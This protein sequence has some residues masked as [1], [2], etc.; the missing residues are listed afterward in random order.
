MANDRFISIS[1]TAGTTLLEFDFPLQFPDELTLV[2]IRA[3]VRVTLAETVDYNITVMSQTLG[4]ALL[5]T[6][7]SLDG[8]VFEI[9][10]ATRVERVSDYDTAVPPTPP[11]LNADF[12]RLTYIQQE[13]KR[14]LSGVVALPDLVSGFL[15]TGQSAYDARGPLAGK[16]AYDGEAEGFTYL[17]TDQDPLQLFIHASAV[18]TWLGP[19]YIGSTD[20]GGGGP[21]PSLAGTAY[22]VADRT[23]LAAL[24]TGNFQAAVL[25]EAGREGLFTWKTGDYSALV[26]ADTAQGI[27][28]AS[29]AVAS[30]AGCW[31]R[32]RPSNRASLTWFGAVIGAAAGANAA[33]NNAAFAVATALAGVSII[34]MPAGVIEFST[35]ININRDGTGLCGVD[36]IPNWGATSPNFGTVLTW[37]GAANGHGVR[38]ITDGVNDVKSPLLENFAVD[39]RGLLGVGILFMSVQSAVGRN[40]HVRNIAT[41]AGSYGYLFSSQTNTSGV[42]AV[43]GSEFAN[44]VAHVTGDANG[45]VCTGVAGQAAVTFCTFRQL[46]GSFEN[47]TFFFANCGDDNHVINI[48]A[49]RLAGG[50]GKTVVCSGTGPKWMVGWWFDG[51]HCGTVDGTAG[52]QVSGAQCRQIHFAHVSGVDDVPN[53]TITGGAEAYYDYYGATY[54]GSLATEQAVKRTPPLQ[55]VNYN[56]DDQTTLDWYKEGSFVPGLTFGGGAVGMTGTFIGRYTRIGDTVFFKIKITLTAKGSSTGTAN[57]TNLPWASVDDIDTPVSLMPITGFASGTLDRP[58]FAYVYNNSDLILLRRVGSAGAAGTTALD[59]TDFTNTTTLEI[60]GTYKV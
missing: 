43:Y 9:A 50:T 53:I 32:V 30:S 48:S 57:I 59:N 52:I 42:Q 18:N 58:L 45:F 35:T 12:N 31:V 10:G 6:S 2:R 54:S 22:S 55:I 20:L 27:Y 46:H 16:S 26:A 37:Y 23:A 13:F 56:N 11:Q 7:A 40:L 25:R 1:P 34:D 51:V 14:D 4:G 33:A 24:A 60:A 8:D 3:D 36:A 44:L 21:P 41:I 17:A 5:L 29:D 38:V 49:A 15:A 19:Y 28:V 39:G 47:G